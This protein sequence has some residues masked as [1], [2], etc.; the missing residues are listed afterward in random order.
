MAFNPKR[1]VKPIEPPVVE[2]CN[3]LEVARDHLRKAA[4][5]SGQAAPYLYALAQVAFLAGDYEASAEACEKS[6]QTEPGNYD[7]LL[8]L[9]ETLLRL[10]RRDDSPREM[11]A[12]RCCPRRELVRPVAKRRWLR[13]LPSDLP[14]W[15]AG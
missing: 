6:L 7:A 12:D 10:A 4:S 1:S 15:R 11:Y 3:E 13:L 8:L 9:A 5:L 2:T 14:G